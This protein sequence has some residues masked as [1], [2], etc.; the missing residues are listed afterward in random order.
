[1]QC[2]CSV[3]SFVVFQTTLYFS[4]LPYKRRDFLKKVIEQK[5]CLFI[6]S[7]AFVWN[8]SHSNKIST[9]YDKK[10]YIGFHVPYLL[11]LSDFNEKNYFYIFL[12]EE[13]DNKFHENPSVG[14]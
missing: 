4:T 3:L 13:I 9:S 1:M 6:F 5:M 14:A 2:A 7:T 12:L 11:F 10:M 8:I